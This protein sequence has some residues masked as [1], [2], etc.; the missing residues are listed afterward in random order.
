MKEG[1]AMTLD[2][3]LRLAAEATPGP[4]FDFVCEAKG[5]GNPDWCSIHGDIPRT[6]SILDHI[7]SAHGIG[8]NEYWA[9]E[10][11]EQARSEHALAAHIA[12]FSPEVAAALVK[13][14]VAAGESAE[15]IDS[16]C[17]SCEGRGWYETADPNRFGEPGDPRQEPCLDS[18][19]VEP[20]RIRASLAALDA[21]LAARP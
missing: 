20:T 2:D 12:A 7:E 4:A 21:V 19:H 6:M 16:Y 1:S 11:A 13:V 18:I 14:A 15:R 3:L 9:R 10:D 8:R 5:H 17:S